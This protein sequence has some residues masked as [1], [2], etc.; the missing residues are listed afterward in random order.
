VRVPVTLALLDRADWERATSVPYPMPNSKPGLVTLPARMEEFPGFA[1]MGSDADILA[2]TISFHEMGHLFAAR[3]GIRPGNA[4]INELVANIFA[5]AYIRSHQPGMEAYLPAPHRDFPTPRYTSLAD[6][7]YL[8][9]AV[10]FS[11]YAWF[12]FQLNRLAFEIAQRGELGQI[13][14]RLKIAFPAAKSD[15]LPERE[16]IR[17][18]ESVAP[19][20]SETLGPLSKPATIAKAAESVCGN[21]G[22]GEGAATYLVIDNGRSSQIVVSQAGKSPIHV[23]AGR[24]QRLSVRAGE[25]LRL[26]NGNCIVAPNEPALAVVNKP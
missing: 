11:N 26:S 21:P 5:Q 14:E 17:R 18:M 23:G 6:L 4:W 7:D 2:E 12:Q 15:H 8:Y 22:S 20:F 3:E 9:D 1:E 13:V 19:G 25:Q 24:W 10:S 16:A